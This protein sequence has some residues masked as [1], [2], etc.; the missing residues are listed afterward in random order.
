ML[1]WEKSV[2]PKQTRKIRKIKESK[3]KTRKTIRDVISTK[4]T[5]KN[6]FVELAQSHFFYSGLEMVVNKYWFSKGNANIFIIGEQHYPRNFVGNGT[7]EAFNDFMQDIKRLNTSVDIMLEERDESIYM[8][9]EMYSPKNEQLI[10]IRSLLHECIRTHKCG[11]VRAHWVD[12]DYSK[13][14]YM[15]S[16]RFS[17]IR[18]L[19]IAESVPKRTLRNALNEMPP[20][21]KSFYADNF[22]VIN[23]TLILRF[24]PELLDRFSNIVGIRTLLTENTIVLKEIGKATL[25]NPDFNLQ[26]AEDFLTGI[27]LTAVTSNEKIFEA[28]RCVMDI[29]TVARMIKSRMKNV[30]IYVGGAHSTNI[31]NMLDQLDY[32]MEDKFP[33]SPEDQDELDYMCGFTHSPDESDYESSYVI[34]P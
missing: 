30:I 20:W 28:A 14:P 13:N 16:N 7:Y 21:L 1:K 31:S 15:I 32:K 4:K 3:S 24:S 5:Q 26:F 22:H 9:P 18:P 34:S 29:Y 19:T 25:V 6:E 10:N 17:P 12:G 2:K 23:G 11:K 8:P 27:I 33:N